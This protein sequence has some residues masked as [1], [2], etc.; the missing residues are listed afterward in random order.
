MFS[1]TP[2]SY[3]HLVQ[4]DRLRMHHLLAAE[5]QQLAGQVGGSFRCGADLIE[6]SGNVA[7]ES[8]GVDASQV[9]V[10]TND[11]QEIVKVMGNPAGELADGFQLLRLS[12]VLLRFSQGRL[13]PNPIQRPAAVIGQGLQR[14]EALRAVG[15]GCVALE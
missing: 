3:T 7:G 10:S 14:F 2:V 8:H 15:L 6:A 1:Y 4:I 12:E 13:G 5:R 9:G 11:S